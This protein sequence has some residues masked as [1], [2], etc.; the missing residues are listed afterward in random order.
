MGIFL[1]STAKRDLVFELAKKFSQTHVKGLELRSLAGGA[2][3]N[4][5]ADSCRVVVRNQNAGEAPYVKI[6]EEIS[7][8][9]EETGIGFMRRESVN[10]WRL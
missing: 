8:F 2:A 6:R 4:S 9:R 7:K 10:P 5:V 3:A 1:L